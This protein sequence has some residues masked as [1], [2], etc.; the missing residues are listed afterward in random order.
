LP[1]FSASMQ[2]LASYASRCKYT[3]GL[4]LEK[5]RRIEVLYRNVRALI[6]YEGTSEIHGQTIARQLLREG[7]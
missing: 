4:A 1:I 7:P 2:P 5:G 3:K 6:I